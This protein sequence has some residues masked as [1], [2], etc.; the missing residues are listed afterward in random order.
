MRWFT[1]QLP[2]SI[3]G[4]IFQGVE[5]PEDET[6]V[7]MLDDATAKLSSAVGSLP[8]LLEQKRLIGTDIL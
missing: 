8:E 2:K 7:F 6:A 1:D 5:N 3:L 4:I